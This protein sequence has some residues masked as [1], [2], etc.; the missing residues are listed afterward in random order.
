MSSGSVVPPGPTRRRLGVGPILWA[1]IP[2]LSLGFLAPVPFAHA[3]VRLRQRRLWAITAAYAI[4]VVALFVFSASREGSW[5]DAV[6]GTVLVA[7]MIVGTAHA[8]V[9]R[10]RV[11]APP[12]ARLATAAAPAAGQL[13]E[14]AGA[15][16]TGDVALAGEL[17]IGHSELP[18]Q[19]DDGGLVDI[20]H[21]P[22]QVLVDRLGLSP[23]QAGQVVQARERLGG[24]AGPEELIAGSG[25]PAATVDAL[26]ERLVFVA[27]ERATDTH[28]DRPDTA[29]SEDGAGMPS[30]PSASEDSTVAREFGIGFVISLSGSFFAFVFTVLLLVSECG[31][32]PCSDWHQRA[33]GVLLFV[34]PPLLVVCGAW[35]LVGAWT[36][37]IAA[38]RMAVRVLWIGTATIWTVWLVM[39]IASP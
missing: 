9:L 5:G 15:I 12:P 14:D 28:D 27:V 11:F 7:L 2:A 38:K 33:A 29:R 22:A 17:R 20:N 23:A 32:G 30:T 34:S 26:R 10:R 6:F 39:L 37:R 16:A 36:K 35:F 8:F 31:T 25:L 3:A 4:G 19:V 18:R 21:V 13:R 1:L 24:F